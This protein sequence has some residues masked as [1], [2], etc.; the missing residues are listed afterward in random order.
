MPISAPTAQASSM[1][2]IQ[3]NQGHASSS[4]VVSG[5]THEQPFMA[6]PIKNKPEVFALTDISDLSNEDDDMLALQIELAENREQLLSR[7]IELKRRRV[8]NESRAS[9][10][11]KGFDLSRELSL[12]I[13]KDQG[14]ETQRKLKALEQE[15]LQIVAQ[16]QEQITVFKESFQIQALQEIEAMKEHWKE[17]FRNMMFAELKAAHDED[18]ARQKAIIGSV[19]MLQQT[20][21]V[22]YE[23]EFRAEMHNSNVRHQ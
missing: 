15:K 18:S 4:V 10:S 1:V 6:T 13:E 12:I 8:Q 5:E 2:P 11:A 9:S 22:E 20:Q 21:L 17:H 23:D 16:A 7:K 14:E 3:D 19:E